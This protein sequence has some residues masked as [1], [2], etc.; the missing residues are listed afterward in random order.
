LVASRTPAKWLSKPKVRTTSGSK[1]CLLPDI[2]TVFITV[3]LIDAF[4]YI[5]QRPF[6][7]DA[8]KTRVVEV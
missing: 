7:L 1:T 3:I 6:A 2:A 5:L 4:F 8:L